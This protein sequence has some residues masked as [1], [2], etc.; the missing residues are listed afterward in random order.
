MGGRSFRGPYLLALLLL[1]VTV[2]PFTSQSTTSIDED[3]PVVLHSVDAWDDANFSDIAVPNGFS[4]TS[5]LDYSDVGVL[6]NN[7][8]EVSRT[9]GWSFILSRNIPVE[10]VLL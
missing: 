1:T 5:Y 3:L 7:K 8:S 4:Q 6:I 9:I 2:S 10:H